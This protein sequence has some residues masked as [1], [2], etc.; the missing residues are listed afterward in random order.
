MARVKKGVNARKKARRLLK[1]AK[2]YRGA[3]SDRYKVA[4]EAVIHA[5]VHSY[6]DR[7]DKKGMF[8]KLWITRISAAVRTEG[9]RYSQLVHG[10]KLANVEINRK[11]LA[12]LALND[13]NAF[14]KLVSL[15]KE[16]IQMGGE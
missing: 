15:A 11:M 13:M 1:A 6:N 4:K 5:G 12:D 14:K 9:V 10:L 7:K 8:R 16:K 2:G 3:R